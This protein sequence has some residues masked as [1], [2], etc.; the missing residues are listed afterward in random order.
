MTKKYWL[1]VL[2]RAV[3]TAAQT[4]IGVISTHTMIGDID[5]PSILS[6]TATST[7]VSVLTSIVS[8]NFGESGTA[9]ILKKKVEIEDKQ[10]ES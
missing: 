3:K 2:E 8:S 10:N 5:W 4:A 6:I 7:I 1:D 9:S